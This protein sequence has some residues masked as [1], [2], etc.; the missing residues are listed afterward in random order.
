M[1]S[2]VQIS[3][4][5]H[6]RASFFR[7]ALPPQAS[8]RSPDPTAAATIARAATRRVL[9]PKIP[10][11]KHASTLLRLGVI[12]DRPEAALALVTKGLELSHQSAGASAKCLQGRRDDAATFPIAL[13]ETGLLEIGE[14]RFANP[15]WY[16]SRQCERG[17]RGCSVFARPRGECA[18]KPREVS[19]SWTTQRLESLVDFEIARIKQ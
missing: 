4:A 3:F 7:M 11:E 6:Q 1:N 13:H 8:P 2:R 5:S 17:G 16:A 19:D 9:F 18:L 15:S 12:G 10:A 14:Q